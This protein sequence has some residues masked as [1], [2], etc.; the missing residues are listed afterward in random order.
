MN[1]VLSR[2]SEE[3]IGFVP[4]GLQVDVEELDEHNWKV[5]HAFDYQAQ[6]DRYTVHRGQ[7]TDFASVPRI[8]AWFIPT[9]G[10]Y[11]KAAILHD[12]LCELAHAGAFERRDADAIFRQAMRTLGVPFLRRWI[13]WAAV[14][15]GAVATKNGLRGWWRDAPRVLLITI[16]FG[17]L[18]A[19]AAILVLATLIVWEVVE[20]V[21]WVPL[22]LMTATKRVNPPNPTWK[23]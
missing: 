21:A 10:K 7:K 2:V 5:L 17:A 19:P 15:W 11:T 23:T 9:Y 4:P 6:V 1:M 8:F 14:R 3:Q 12:H 18:L 16:P 22:K 20:V 13:M